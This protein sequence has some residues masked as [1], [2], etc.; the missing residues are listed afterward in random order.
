MKIGT[1][2]ATV[3]SALAMPISNPAFGATHSDQPLTVNIKRLSL[4][5]ALRIGKA[6]IDKCRKEGVS[7]TVTVIDRGGNAQVVLRDTLAMDVTIPISM[8]K[9]YTA[10]E[11]NSPSGTIGDRFKS[12]Y[13]VPKMDELLATAGGIPINIAGNIMGGIGVSGAPSP[14][15]DEACAK[16]GLSAVSDD[17]EME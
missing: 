3:V 15:I 10:M 7:V 12:S 8:K 1:V 4:D 2:A 13:D 11:F 6:A 17:L 16:A 5:T 9:A 14:M